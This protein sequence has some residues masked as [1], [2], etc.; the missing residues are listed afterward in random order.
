[1]VT[2]AADFHAL[3]ALS[4]DA[5]PGMDERPLSSDERAVLTH[6]LNRVPADSAVRV[7]STIETQLHRVLDVDLREDESGIRRVHAPAKQKQRA[8][9][10]AEPRPARV[11]QI[12]LDK[13]DVP[14]YAVCPWSRR[15]R[16][17][18]V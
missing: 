15:T 7:H 17:S 13:F 9:V 4:G 8:P 5:L 1:M 12:S 11:P 18:G 6:L 3:L 2:L 16:S 14:H 10:R